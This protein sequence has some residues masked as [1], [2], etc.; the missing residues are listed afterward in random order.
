MALSCV[1]YS[2][3]KMKHDNKLVIVMAL[4]AHVMKKKVLKRAYLPY[5]SK[6]LA[7][8]LHSLCLQ[9]STPCASNISLQAPLLVSPLF[10]QV[11]Q[12]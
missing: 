12:P 9:R 3:K 2:S 5:S 1:S 7:T 11:L 6:L 8:T 10:S 4:K